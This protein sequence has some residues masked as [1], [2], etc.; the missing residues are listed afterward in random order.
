MSDHVVLMADI[1]DSRKFNSKELISD[2]KRLANFI[3]KKWKK[4]I[5][6]PITITLGDEFQSVID[7]EM[8]AVR[9]IFEI[10]EFI[11]K[12][13]FQ[14]KLRYVMNY[15][16]IETSVN[17]S[18][19]YEMLG[20]GLSK[21]REKLNKLKTS[22]KRFSFLSLQNQKNQVNMNKLFVIYQNFVDQWRQN[23]FEFVHLF[24]EGKS[25]Q[26]IAA[27]LNINTASAWK[28]QKSLHIEE[29]FIC[30]DLIFSLFL[31]NDD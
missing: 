3:N 25:Y 31:M 23:E 18:I 10:E 9:I 16:R 2:F 17:S 6:S 24:L 13:K 30:K 5:V 15:G 14:F 8:N 22:K 29:Y 1:I 11:I 20:E 4:V 27:E 19:A 26:S 28:R 7:T 21:T 12:S